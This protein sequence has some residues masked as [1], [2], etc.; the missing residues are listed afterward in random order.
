M[1]CYR[2]LF[3]RYPA[4][5]WALSFREAKDKGRPVY[6][7]DPDEIGPGAFECDFCSAPCVY[8]VKAYLDFGGGRWVLIDTHDGREATCADDACRMLARWYWAPKGN[9]GRRRREFLN[10][11]GKTIWQVDKSVKRDLALMVMLKVEAKRR[12]NDGKKNVGLAA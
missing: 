4:E 8:D 9:G 10:T 2:E 11:V 5:M 6:E 1:N 7:F 12:A 3:A